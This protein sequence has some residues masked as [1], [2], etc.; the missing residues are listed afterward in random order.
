MDN[1]LTESMVSGSTAA[2]YSALVPAMPMRDRWVAEIS[3]LW[4]KKA[5]RV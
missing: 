4:G 5:I 3:E 2:L 1:G